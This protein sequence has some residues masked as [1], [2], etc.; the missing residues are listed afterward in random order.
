MGTFVS[1][2]ESRTGMSGGRERK[3]FEREV[4]NKIDEETSESAAD[5]MC[6]RVLTG[7]GT[8]EHCCLSYSVAA[9]IF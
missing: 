9:S 3:G 4:R 5:D 1:L 2:R 7:R 8:A 6:S